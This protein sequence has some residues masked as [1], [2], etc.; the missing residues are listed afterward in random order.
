MRLSK[1]EQKEWPQFQ[2]GLVW[3]A[4]FI[5]LFFFRFGIALRLSGNFD[6][7][8]YLSWVEKWVGTDPAGCVGSSH[9]PGIA[10]LWLP[11]AFIGKTFGGIFGEPLEEWIAAFCGLQSFLFWVASLFIIHKTIAITGRTCP[12]RVTL[13]LVFSVPVL[14]FAATRN[15]LV[16]S[17]ELFL[18]LLIVNQLFKDRC[19]T[20]LVLICLLCFVRPSDF[21][22]FFPLMATFSP[23]KEIRKL[24][25]GLS[26]VFLGIFSTAIAYI[27][28]VKGYHSTNLIYLL[29]N[30]DWYSLALIFFRTDF[31]IFWTQPLLLVW[32]IYLFRR[33]EALDPISKQ[34]LA[35]SF[36]LFFIALIWPTHGSSFGYRYLIGVYP[37]ALLTL[38]KLDCD[39]TKIWK[40]VTLR[41]LFS[42]Q[43]AWLLLLFWVVPASETLW[44]W[45]D[46]NYK[47][48]APP[49]GIL[50]SWLSNL[51][52]FLSLSKFSPAGFWWVKLQGKGVTFGLLGQ[53]TDYGLSGALGVFF[54]ILSLLVLFLFLFSSYLLLKQLAMKS[55]L[56]SK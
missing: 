27:A 41:L 4:S 2:W 11:A 49:F 50:G 33:R 30:F 13:L 20:A 18:G 40:S 24:F 47:G 26:L 48:L 1:K 35:A 9:P 6:E 55:R 51:P 22:Y 36:F 25:V 39:F 37:L 21:P 44:P 23:K 34:A 12:Q 5:F 43:A 8:C 42:Y 14:F 15:L 32:V 19:L 56:R 53:Q 52:E 38:L 10:L 17:A 29:K 3:A 28:I 46:V 31:G 45:K 54:S 7:R 16:H